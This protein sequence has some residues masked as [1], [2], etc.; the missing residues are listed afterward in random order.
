MNPIPNLIPYWYE[1]PRLIRNR[2]PDVTI[3]ISHEYLMKYYNEPLPNDIK[4]AFE[5]GDYLKC[6][7]KIA[8]DM[9]E[10]LVDIPVL[11]YHIGQPIADETTKWL[12]PLPWTERNGVVM[13]EHSVFTPLVQSFEMIRDSGLSATLMT[14]NH[15]HDASHWYPYVESYDIDA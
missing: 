7:N 8:K 6:S 10:Q 15:T 11:Y 14:A 5:Y 2:A 9:F 1:Y 4:R 13:L 3:V 12:D